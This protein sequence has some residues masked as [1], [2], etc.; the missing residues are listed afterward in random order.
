MQIAMLI[1]KSL[2]ALK[3]LELSVSCSELAL[4]TLLHR[5]EQAKVCEEPCSPTSHTRCRS[6]EGRNQVRHILKEEGPKHFQQRRNS[7][8]SLGSH[9]EREL[10]SKSTGAG[11]MSAPG[12]SDCHHRAANTT[13]GW[14]GLPVISLTGEISF[15]AP[16]PIDFLTP[17]E[18]QRKLHS[19]LACYPCSGSLSTLFKP[20]LAAPCRIGTPPEAG[21]LGSML[22]LRNESWNHRAL[23]GCFSRL[24]APDLAGD[25]PVPCRG[26]ALDGL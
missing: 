14:H 18:K 5:S 15:S 6:R 23:R 24:W 26:N 20:A 9:S 10:K 25:V 12:L 8:W 4:E 11:S 22:T 16:L 19:P 7:S 2:N 3:C 21:V 13:M 1:L 17:L